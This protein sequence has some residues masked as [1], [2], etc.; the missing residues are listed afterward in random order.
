MKLSVKAASRS[1]SL[2]H[3]RFPGQG[4]KLDFHLLHDDEFFLGTKREGSLV[5]VVVVLRARLESVL[6]VVG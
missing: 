4:F 6:C 2:A 3:D 5:Y 1:V